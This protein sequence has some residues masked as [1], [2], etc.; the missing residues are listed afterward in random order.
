MART[1]FALDSNLSK[2]MISDSTI[3]HYILR[4][5]WSANKTYDLR[6]HVNLEEKQFI[7]PTKTPV[8]ITFIH[9]NHRFACCI[10][11]R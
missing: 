8:T 6:P 7:D 11:R 1:E 9:W 2:T 4:F 5:L 3:M 10:G